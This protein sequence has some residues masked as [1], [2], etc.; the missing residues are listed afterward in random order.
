VKWEGREGRSKGGGGR[1][2]EREGEE[3]ERRSGRN[4]DIV[5]KKKD[6]VCMLH[7][8]HVCMF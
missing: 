3:T 1:R 2:D 8:P 6:S 4:S 5:R 7:I